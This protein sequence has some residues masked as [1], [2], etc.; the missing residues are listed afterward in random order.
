MGV[1]VRL[2]GHRG[3]VP[4]LALGTGSV[5]SAHLLLWGLNK[6]LGMQGDGLGW[7]SW[8]EKEH[9][10]ESELILGGALVVSQHYPA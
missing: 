8:M 1:D 6:A 2:R 5:Y 9:L 10:A 4:T 7:G 3:A